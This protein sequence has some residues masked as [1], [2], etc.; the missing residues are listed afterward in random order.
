MKGTLR[1]VIDR[2]ME[3]VNENPALGDQP[4]LTFHEDHYDKAVA[5]SLQ[6]VL[7]KSLTERGVT[8]TVH[9]IMPDTA[10]AEEVVH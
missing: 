6:L 1:N 7:D 8:I 10:D 2:L 9:R 3:A 5:V 4:V